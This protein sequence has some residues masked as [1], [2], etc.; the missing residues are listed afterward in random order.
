MDWSHEAADAGDTGTSHDEQIR[1][2]LELLWFSAGHRWLRTPGAATVRISTG[3]VFVATR[4]LVAY[5]AYTGRIIWELPKLPVEAGAAPREMVALPD[6]LY[7]AAG[8]RCVEL[9][10]STG[11]T[12]SS[13]SLPEGL[14][15]TWSGL[16]ADETHL[17]A[18]ANRTLLCYRRRTGSLLWQHK[19]DLPVQSIAL[20]GRKLFCAIQQ[21]KRGK[22]ANEKP[23]PS[24]IVALDLSTGA[25]AWECIGSGPLRFSAKQNLLS[26]GQVVLVP[27][28]GSVLGRLPL[29][30]LAVSGQRII[31]GTDDEVTSYE[32]STCKKLHGPV[33]WQ[34]RGCT[35]LRAGLHLL[36]T[37]Y[38][39]N[40][41]YV[42]LIGGQIIPVLGVRAACSNN[43]YPANGLVNA[44][45]LT[46][47]CTCNYLPVSYALAPRHL[48]LRQRQ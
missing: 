29:P 13:M 16:H 32:M 21:P 11:R 23:L 1:P 46:G 36:T 22:A 14:W 7:L 18:V 41:A 47:G 6:A 26:A 28:D 3:R 39:G 9:D 34:R 24:L 37:R 31:A 5:D 35:R 33:R 30:V 25:R 45:N 8:R 27:A 44:P 2:P 17:V 43:L 4:G 20:G 19:F 42:D 38:R 15:G 40:A 12:V 48:F 10:P